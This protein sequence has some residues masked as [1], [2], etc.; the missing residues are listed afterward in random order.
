MSEQ[1]DE[2]A[3]ECLSAVRA[4]VEFCESCPEA[5]WTAITAEEGWPVAAVIR[6]IA[7]SGR[8]LV[9]FAQEMAAGHDVAT[10]MAE[11]DG[12]NAGHIDDWSKTTRLEAIAHLSAVGELAARSVRG[13]SPDQLTGEHMFA[14]YG[15][16]RTTARMARGFALHALEHLES[17]RAA[18][19]PASAPA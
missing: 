12:W 14:V 1:G 13:Y 15:Q 16:P 7:E 19:G 10:T 8:L 2:I 5:G 18:A 3:R 4:A 11:I 9:G 17:A 6:H